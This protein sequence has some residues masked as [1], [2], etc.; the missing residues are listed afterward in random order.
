MNINNILESTHRLQHHV[1]LPTK[2]L[3]NAPPVDGN[4]ELQEKVCEQYS[5][6][7]HEDALKLVEGF[8][9]D[10]Q[11]N[12]KSLVFNVYVTRLMRK[13]PQQSDYRLAKK[14][15]ML[16]GLLRDPSLPDLSAVEWERNVHSV[17]AVMR[18]L[19]LDSDTFLVVN[20]WFKLLPFFLQLLSSFT[21]TLVKDVTFQLILECLKRVE[22]GK[23]D[24]NSL[25]H[26]F[27]KIQPHLLTS[28][29]HNSSP[30][31]EALSLLEKVYS[32]QLQLA[33]LTSLDKV[34]TLMEFGISNG[35]ENSQE[36]HQMLE[37]FFLQFLRI[38]AFM[39]PQEFR[40]QV[41]WFKT[42]CHLFLRPLATPMV[43]VHEPLVLSVMSY[44][45]EFLTELHASFETSRLFFNQFRLDFV[46]IVSINWKELEDE[47]LKKILLETAEIVKK[48]YGDNLDQL[49][50][51]P[52]FYIQSP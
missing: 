42:I 14:R 2:T 49:N 16:R 19:C 22:R 13:L 32:A 17:I 11:K 35:A 45:N 24:S 29:P 51:I 21:E 50:A 12:T 26:L 43:Y 8:D 3:H 9:C 38:S 33:R 31:N 7:N 37:F 27:T 6:E 44:M 52:P 25:S 34:D 5:L 30:S 28:L 1:S 48:L 47:K 41:K 40:F 46:Y 20:N 23:L 4:R 10:F 36:N 39:K 15:E 18:K